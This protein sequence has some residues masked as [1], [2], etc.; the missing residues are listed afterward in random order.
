GYVTPPPNGFAGELVV[1]PAS[2]RLQLLEPFVPLVESDLEALPVLLKIEGKCTTDHISPA[3]PWLRYR[4]HLDHI[5]GNAYIGASNTFTDERG[6]AISTLTGEQA[7]LPEVAREYRNANQGWIVIADVN[8]GEGSSREHAAM[9][10]RF[11]GCRAIIARSFAHIAET[12]LK[13]QG[14]LP[15]VFEEAMDWEL[16][17]ADDRFTI[18]G[19]AELGS[20]S[21]ILVGVE[22]SDGTLDEFSCR[23]SL[24]EQQVKWFR[25]G[26]ALNYLRQQV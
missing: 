23:H 21:R 1:D 13:K 26:S 19:L 14:V 20:G 5:S 4:G 11:L 2:D 8:Y 7:S 17:R 16:I 9:S 24:S 10:P 3:G 18:S 6:T 25:A 12:N 22:H 15:L